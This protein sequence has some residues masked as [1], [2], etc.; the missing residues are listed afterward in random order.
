MGNR[1]HHDLQ[2]WQNAVALVKSVYSLTKALPDEERFGLT[3][4][5]RRAAISVPSNV[6][7][8]AG[9]SSRREFYR[10]LGIARGSL[11]EVETQLRI[12]LDLGYFSDLT[13]IE[14]EMDDVFGLLG[15]LMNSLEGSKKVKSC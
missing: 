5:M 10:F 4:Q 3:A 11:C 9:R 12:G 1:R 13:E 14:K 8:G 6:A 7:E 15:G 2:V